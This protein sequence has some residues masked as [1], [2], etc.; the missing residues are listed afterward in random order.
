MWHLPISCNCGI[1]HK[2][3]F[4]S[5]TNH[6]KAMVACL[7]IL[8]LFSSKSVRSCVNMEPS[9]I[10]ATHNIHG[11]SSVFFSNFFLILQSA[12][13]MNNSY[14]SY[15]WVYILMAALVAY[16]VMWFTQWFNEHTLMQGTQHAAHGYW[17]WRIKCIIKVIIYTRIRKH[18]I[19]KGDIIILQ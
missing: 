4:A 18:S 14:V 8:L 5:L 7:S 10:V 6:A 17:S 16:L 19:A 13:S 9:K 2:T 15:H 1:Y 3:W 11:M 12:F